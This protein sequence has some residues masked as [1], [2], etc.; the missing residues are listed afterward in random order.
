VS[1]RAAAHADLVAAASSVDPADLTDVSIG[2]TAVCDWI[3]AIA[4]LPNT[5][6]L[7]SGA[8]WNTCPPDHANLP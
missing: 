7:A 5:D 6:L 2:P 1:R 8:S 3:S 4:T